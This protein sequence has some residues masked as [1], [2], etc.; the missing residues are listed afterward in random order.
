MLMTAEDAI[1]T[2]HMPED[3]FSFEEARRTLAFEEF[4]V[5][6]TGVASAKRVRKKV[7]APQIKD[8]KCIADFARDLPFELTNAQKRVINEIAADIRKPIPMNR[9]VQGDVGSGK[10]I[11][12]AA[13]MYA[14]AMQGYASVLMAPTEVLAKQHYSGLKKLFGKLDI[15][16]AFLSGSQKAAER[17]ENL[18]LIESGEAKIVIGT[19]ALITGSVQIPKLA[20]AIADEQ[21]RFGVRQRT[22]LGGSETV[23]NLVMTATPIPRTLSLILC[24]DLDIS[25]IDELPPAESLFQQ[26]Q[27]EKITEKRLKILCSTSLTR[28][29]RHILSVRLS[30]N[31][32]Q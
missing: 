15:K 16:T 5:L 22:A 11:V 19:H 9:L 1:R 17:R 23:H 32:R 30:R 3:M 26:W 20:L 8:V 10:T 28:A 2:I 24:G 12:A 6:Q 13:V 18:E 29:D 21:H 27:L 25:T 14:V 7:N 4:L 31:P